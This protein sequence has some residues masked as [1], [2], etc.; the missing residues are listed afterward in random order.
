MRSARRWRWRG[1]R[2][3]GVCGHHRRV[4]HLESTRLAGVD[5]EYLYLDASHFRFHDG[6]RGDPL[7]VA[8]GI[9]SHGAPRLLALEAV[10]A[11][12]HDAVVAFLR[13]MVARGLRA[14]LLHEHRRR[15][16]LIG[17]VEQSSPTACGNA[18]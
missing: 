16:G 5:L 4:R 2:C 10:S 13:G 11:E 9:T 8:C 7:L 17:A 1:R 15:P 6:A 18:T 3:R 12:S 14:P